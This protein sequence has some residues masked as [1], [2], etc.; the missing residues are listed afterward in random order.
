MGKLLVGRIGSHGEV[1]IA[2]SAASELWLLLVV[3]S[4]VRIIAPGGKDRGADSKRQSALVVALSRNS[5]VALVAMRVRVVVPVRMKARQDGLPVHV[6]CVLAG[7]ESVWLR[8]CER[9]GVGAGARG[10]NGGGGM[11]GELEMPLSLSPR[12][13]STAGFLGGRWA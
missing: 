5:I 8:A 1:G 11:L 7:C 6:D 10:G 13:S 2:V 9:A 4:V 12:E 3:A